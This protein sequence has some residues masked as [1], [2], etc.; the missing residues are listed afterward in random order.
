MDLRG[1]GHQSSANMATKGGRG[2]G[3]ASR[4]CGGGGHGGR[5]GGGRG[6]GSS[7][8]VSFA[9]SA[10]RKGILLFAASKGL[11]PPS[12]DLHRRVPPQRQVRMV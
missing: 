7:N 11:M 12:L 1:G 8:K 9:N 4:G 10:A 5:G 3:N 6:Q 2:G